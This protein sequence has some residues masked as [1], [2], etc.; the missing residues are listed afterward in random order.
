ME[1]KLMQSIV[2]KSKDPDSR[3]LNPRNPKEGR[4]KKN[5]NKKVKLWYID[6]IL[7]LYF[8]QLKVKINHF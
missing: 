2:S 4:K 8:E 7:F 6:F 1:K 3:V 5:K